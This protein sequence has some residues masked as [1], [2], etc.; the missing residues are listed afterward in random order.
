M[1]HPRLVS[2]FPCIHKTCEKGGNPSIT[3][4]NLDHIPYLPGDGFVVCRYCQTLTHSFDGLLPGWRVFTYIVTSQA[5]ESF[6]MYPQN[7][8]NVWPPM[9][10]QWYLV[11]Q[12]RLWWWLGGF[13]DPAKPGP[14]LWEV[15]GLD[16]RHPYVCV[17]PH[18]CETFH[19]HPKDM[20]NVCQPIHGH[21]SSHHNP[22]LTGNGLV[23]RKYCKTLT[24]IF[25]IT[26]QISLGMV[27]WFADPANSWPTCLG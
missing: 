7:T 4:C 14:T 9:N 6:S 15:C 20:W 12:P 13:L 11:S 26:P 25:G 27:W 17:T 16:R 23:V 24:H 10:G 3:T 19:M 21:W 2:P 18:T 1:L 5:C 22:H 8:C